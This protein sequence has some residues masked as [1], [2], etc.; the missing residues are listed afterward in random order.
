VILRQEASRLRKAR[1]LYRLTRLVRLSV[2]GQTNQAF[3]REAVSSRHVFDTSKLQ[4]VEIIRTRLRT[5]YTMSKLSL[6][7]ATLTMPK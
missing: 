7:V 2:D 3:P 6:R 5:W 1:V 4:V